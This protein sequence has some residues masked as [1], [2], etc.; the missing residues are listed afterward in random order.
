MDWHYKCNSYLIVLLLLQNSSYYIL[1][2]TIWGRTFLIGQKEENVVGC[3]NANYMLMLTLDAS[4]RGV[5]LT[6]SPSCTQVMICKPSLHFN[7]SIKARALTGQWRGNVELEDWEW[8]Q[9][10]RQK[11]KRGERGQKKGRREPWWTRTMR[12]GETTSSKWGL[13]AGE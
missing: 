7:W 13:I 8:V 10:E 11:S 12:P 3:P 9:I 6:S 4:S 5:G 1:F 2:V